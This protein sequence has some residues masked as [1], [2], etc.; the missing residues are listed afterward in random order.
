MSVIWI[1]IEVISFFLRTPVQCSAKSAWAQTVSAPYMSAE[2]WHPPDVVLSDDDDDGHPPLVAEAVDSAP[3]LPDPNPGC[4]SR[5]RGG[6]L[7]SFQDS[8]VRT[9]LLLEKG[10]DCARA[11]YSRMQHAEFVE[12]AARDTMDLRALHKLDQDR[13]IFDRLKLLRALHGEP[14]QYG[15]L[16]HR[17]CEK[18][19]RK[20]M[21]VGRMRLHNIRKAV[22]Q[23]LLGP[24]LDM[25]HIRRPDAVDKPMAAQI[26]TYLQELYE[27]VA[28]VLPE[29]CDEVIMQE[30]AALEFLG[31]ECP[32]TKKTKPDRV[33]EDGEERRYLPP[34]T[35][36][37]LW[38]EHSIMRPE[39]K[40]G[41]TTFYRTCNSKL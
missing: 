6:Q 11:C 24:P 13:V 21:R 36:R 19:Y 22:C 2:C 29:D 30:D 37:T 34:G 39:H 28:E 14:L 7:L 16:G 8:F 31:P 3:P 25:R 4:G 17:V 20:L 15:Y 9:R 12:A 33:T 40:V 18:G 32:E 1:S 38:Q 5:S 10:C 27:S 23:H 35:V 26:I 41:R